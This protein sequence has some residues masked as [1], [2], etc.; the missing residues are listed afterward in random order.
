[1]SDAVRGML[2]IDNRRILPVGI[3]FYLK[4]SCTK[5]FI[6]LESEGQIVVQSCGEYEQLR[7]YD[8]AVQTDTLCHY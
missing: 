2:N 5:Q 7:R 6:R 1:M 8:T 3:T 4:T